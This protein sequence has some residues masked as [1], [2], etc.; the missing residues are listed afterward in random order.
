MDFFTFI[1]STSVLSKYLTLFVQEGFSNKS[2][3]EIFDAIRKIGIT[4]EQDMFVK[5]KG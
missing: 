4:A 3:K 1:D 2:Y 5:T